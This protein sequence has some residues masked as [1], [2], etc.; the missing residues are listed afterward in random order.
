MKKL[1]LLFTVLVATAT[2]WA[3]TQ[4]VV[5]IVEQTAKVTRQSTM[6]VGEVVLDGQQSFYYLYSEDLTNYETVFDAIKD[7][8]SVFKSGIY[9]ELL[10]EIVGETEE[11]GIAVCSN[12]A[13]E[14]TMNSDWMSA[15]NAGLACLPNTTVVSSSSE[16]LYETN[17][18]F[19]AMCIGDLAEFS[20]VDNT[21]N[22]VAVSGP[23]G[24][25]TTN[26]I[27]NVTYTVI[28]G[29]LYKFID[30][31]VEYTCEMITVIYTRVE[32]RTT[33]TG[34]VD[35]DAAEPKC[36]QRYNVMGQPVGRDYKGIVIENGKKI[37]E[38]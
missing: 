5:N 22:P 28:D 30:R 13:Y 6:Y 25:L 21:E 32:L 38:R 11:F 12:S 36:G 27:D 34:I 9:S 14:S 8:M 3:Q 2:L 33:V 31:H 19:A 37:I 1:L 18:D 29:T 23:M 17:A 16:N 20:I 7:C 35:I 4:T 10:P 26:I 24:K 15:T